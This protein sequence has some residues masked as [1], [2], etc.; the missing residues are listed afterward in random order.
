MNCFYNKRVDFQRD[1]LNFTFCRKNMSS[2]IVYLCRHNTYI[3]SGV[4]LVFDKNIVCVVCSPTRLLELTYKAIKLNYFIHPIRNRCCRKR[5]CFKFPSSAN[6]S[7]SSTRYY[8]ALSKQD[9]PQ[10]GH[11]SNAKNSVLNNEQNSFCKRTE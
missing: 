10:Q 11:I 5:I 6:S 9:R 4:E 3:F 1:H 7:R 8:S 2:E